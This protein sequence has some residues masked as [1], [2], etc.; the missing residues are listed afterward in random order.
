MQQFDFR[1]EQALAKR[2]A[3]QEALN[4]PNM[5]QASMVSGHYVAPSLGD[6]LVSGLRSYN[7]FKDVQNTEKEIPQIYKERDTAMQGDMSAMLAALRGKPAETIAPAT[8]NDD[9]GNVNPSVQMPAQPGSMEALY[10]TAA[11]SQFPQFQQMGMQGMVQMPQLEAQQKEREDARLFRQQE[12]QAARDARAQELQIRLQDQRTS[13]A[14]KLQAQRELQQMQIDA[15]REMQKMQVQNAAQ[16][17]FQPVQTAQGVM[18]FNARTG[19]MEPIMGGNGQPIVGAQFDP[20]LQ[21]SLAGA[22]AG[23]TTEAKSRAEAK[24]LAP[25]AVAQ[26]DEAVKLVD[27]LLAAPGFKQAV[28][29]SRLLGV[30]KIPG[31]SAKDFDIRLDQ[32]KGKQFLQAF[33]SLKGGGAI[34]EMEGKKATDAIA[35][36]DAAGSEAEFT[37]AAREFQDVIRAGASRA[38]AAAG[39]AAPQAAP[40]QATPKR[41]KFDAQGNIIP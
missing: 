5:P 10:Q 11:K 35:R 23:A 29:G 18:A 34:T 9:E 4:N 13:Q 25:Q 1:L 37:K 31:T 32:L 20:S 2:K 16:P 38:K 19:R 40:I 27:D 3:A 24:I 41:L 33:E 26:A 30:Q 6:A 36:M 22:K 39:Q 12:A 7:A 21:G 15:R 8:P 28:G 14:E 17:Y